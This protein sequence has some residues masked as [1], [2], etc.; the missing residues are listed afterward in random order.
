MKLRKNTENLGDLRNGCLT[1]WQLSAPTLI[2][3]LVQ[4]SA[5]R[6]KIF[7][8]NTLARIV[9]GTQT[10]LA[11]VAGD[12]RVQAGK[13]HRGTGTI[14]PHEA[15]IKSE[16]GTGNSCFV[17]NRRPRAW[18]ELA[19]LDWSLSPRRSSRR[20]TAPRLAVTT[21]I[22]MPPITRIPATTTAAATARNSPPSSSTAIPARS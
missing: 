12:H 8:N 13:D 16:T 22:V 17:T 18:C 7:A 10:A 19:F 9:A 11:R 15:V 3:G 6:R 20:P 1:F 21:A 5:N 4:L 14:S 2:P